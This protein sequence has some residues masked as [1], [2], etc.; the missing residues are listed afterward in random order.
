MIRVIERYIATSKEIV[1]EIEAAAADE[2]LVRL[3]SATHALKGSSLTVGSRLLGNLCQTVEHAAREG[4]LDP[5]QIT[6]IRATWERLRTEL[7]QFEQALR[8]TA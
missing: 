1:D 5:R 7:E 3:A 2:D 8:Q 6:P 4:G